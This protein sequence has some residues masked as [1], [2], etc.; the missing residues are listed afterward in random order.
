M[1]TFCGTRICCHVTA[2][3]WNFTVSYMSPFCIFAI[4]F[5]S[6]Q[7][8]PLW[9]RSVYEGILKVLIELLSTVFKVF[10]NMCYDTL[11]L[12]SIISFF[13]WERYVWWTSSCNYHH[14]AVLSSLL[15]ITPCPQY[16]VLQTPTALVIRDQHLIHSFI[17]SFH[18]HMQNAMIP[19]RSQELLP[20]LSVM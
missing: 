20:F 1:Y 9:V 17:H 5:I 2:C 3:H 18:W 8:E 11:I 7:N 13:L 12:S 19:C 4:C 15:H 10:P 14:L 6:I 16:C